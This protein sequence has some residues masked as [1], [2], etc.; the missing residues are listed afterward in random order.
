[1]RKLFNI[2]ALAIFV[3]FMAG[4]FVSTTM[5]AQGTDFF[6]RVDNNDN[7]DNRADK[8]ITIEGMNHENP[9]APLGSGLLIMVAAG[10]GYA[11]SRSKKL[12]KSV[13]VLV[14]V[15]LLLGMTQCKKEM[16][17]NTEDNKIFVTLEAS[18]GRTVFLPSTAGFNWNNGTE[19]V[20][21][22]GSTSGYLGQLSAMGTG[23]DSQINRIEFSGEITA[24][25]ASETIY[26]FYLGNASRTFASGT[27]TTVIDFSHQ[28][29]G[30]EATVTNLLIAIA[31][32]ELE[33][34]DGN[35]YIATTDLRVKTAIAYFRLSNFK[36]ANNA[37]ETIYL[38]GDDVFSSATINFKEG[39]V[40][41]NDKGNI[42][43][44]TNGEKYVALIKSTD[45]STVLNF[46]SNSAS[47]EM[48]FPEGI[49]ERT[50]YSD[51]TAPLPVAAA[52][53]PEGVLP[54]L[55][56]VA[57][58]KKVRFSKGNLKCT[59]NA[60]PD[61]EGHYDWSSASYTW[62][63]MDK[64]YDRVEVADVY[65]SHTD[66][67]YHDVGDEH[68][69]EKTLSLMGWGTTGNNNLPYDYKYPYNTSQG[70]YGYGYGPNSGS[71][72]V[73]NGDDW[74]WCMGG[75][76]SP[77]RTLTAI[78][79]SWL[80]G[81]QNGGYSYTPTP[82]TNCR[83]SSTVCGKTNARHARARIIKDDQVPLAEYEYING[84]VIFPDEYKHPEDMADLSTSTINYIGESGDSFDD[85]SIVNTLTKS[86]WNKMEVAGAVFLPASGQR[87]DDWITDNGNNDRETFITDVNLGGTYWSSTSGRK[88]FFGA[89]HFYMGPEPHSL[90]YSVRLVTDGD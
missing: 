65:D 82:G 12:R 55:F 15:V 74:G 71:L 29:D 6:F 40:L 11:L 87:Y 60:T 62:S 77:W 81:V 63:F 51:E 16:V 44:G 39:T 45:A 31:P 79:W 24:P 20:Y 36:D 34:A 59:T 32:G 76:D 8:G 84:L 69:N 10:A 30:S 80:M 38:H 49:R 58:G 75:V 26:F 4:L 89:G 72:S 88:F 9:I 85:P 23:N 83:E 3:F 56:S 37:D 2:K 7:Y 86:D 42:N 90:G 35:S 46:D 66:S 61:G 33:P 14:A 67:W 17:S 73:T 27:A 64:Q 25:T 19:Y 52:D 21:V 50:F 78:E 5:N 48:T 28:P 22:G 57:P 13:T 41:G 70:Y 1:M 18:N 54:G 43:V 53:L 68:S 47:G